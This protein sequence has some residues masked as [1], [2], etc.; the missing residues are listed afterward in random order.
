[1]RPWLAA[2]IVS[3][4]PSTAYA[5]VTGRDPLEATKAA[6]A[7]VVGEDAPRP[8]QVAAAAPVH[9][10]VSLFWGELLVRALPRR[11]RALWGAVAGLGIAALDLGVVGRRFPAIRRLPL[12]PQLA[13][14]ALF[15]AVVGALSRGRRGP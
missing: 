15:G 13:D 8:V 3:G 1:V 10:A 7:L 12:G 14:H 5:V 2:A 11:R 6:G 9:L 4:V